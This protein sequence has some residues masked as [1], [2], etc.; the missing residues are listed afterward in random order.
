MLD[1]TPL[2]RP[3]PM[4]L[5]GFFHATINATKQAWRPLLV[6]WAV[7]TLVSIAVIVA[8]GVGALGVVAAAIDDP[9][10]LGAAFPILG[11]LG[12]AAIVVMA[13]VS[14]K[15]AGMSAVLAYDVA[16]GESPT[17]G[18]AWRRSSG[19]VPRMAPVLILLVILVLAVV[20]ALLAVVVMTAGALQDRSPAGVLGVL[21]IFLL[22]G[23]AQP[24]VTWWLRVKLLYTVQ[25]VAIEGVGGIAGMRRSWTLTRGGFWRTLGY[26]LIGS[27]AISTVVSPIALLG[28][29]PLLALR[30][31]NDVDD[32]SQLWMGLSAAIPLVLVTLSVLAL[33]Q[34]VAEPLMQTYTAYLFIDQVRRS[35]LPPTP[36]APSPV[37]PGGYP[38]P[39]PYWGQPPSARPPQASP[40]S[41]APVPQDPPPAPPPPQPGG[42]QVPS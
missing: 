33:S 27:F 23:T 28:Q 7:P 36:S 11:A 1:P 29:L 41:P 26:Y 17:L 16:R 22:L 3:S 9:R 24:V 32:V 15:A 30:F 19:F 37:T 2:L 42:W 4:D 40:G 8:G 6:I 12:L 25:A 20:G 34:L 21:A 14:A 13:V 35:E 18:G 5:A 31:P 39:Q 38:A 10:A